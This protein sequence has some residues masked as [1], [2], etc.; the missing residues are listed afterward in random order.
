ML[1]L[2]AVGKQRA[3]PVAFPAKVVWFAWESGSLR[4]A[5]RKAAEFGSVV[6]RSSSAA[7]DVLA[8]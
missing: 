4:F 1:Q 7:V 3:R 2:A 8:L 6:D 5:R